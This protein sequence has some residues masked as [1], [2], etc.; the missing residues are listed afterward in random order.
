MTCCKKRSSRAAQRQRAVPSWGGPV[1]PEERLAGVA[2]VYWDPAQ[3]VTFHSGAS[4]A[5]VPN[6]GTLG[7]SRDLVPPPDAFVAPINLG[8]LPTYDAGGW[9]DSQRATGTIPYAY[10]NTAAAFGT[11]PQPS[12]F[13][14]RM[15]AVVKNNGGGNR[16]ILRG[17]DW[18]A[19]IHPT[20][21]PDIVEMPIGTSLGFDETTVPPI[22]E[23]ALYDISFYPPGLGPIPNTNGLADLFIN[24]VR[25]SNSPIEPTIT[26]T[27]S[28]LSI[29]AILDTAGSLAAAVLMPLSAAPADQLLATNV[30][31]DK[32]AAVQP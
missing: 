30:M 13:G 21:V 22:G 3:S 20:D 12:L 16:S 17:V 27:E 8:N 32:L 19:N 15:L 28:F 26:L 2:M 23:W 6:L 11:G 4:V 1:S 29:T 31:L 25:V 5:S 14:A 9:I 24:N 7:P 10:L 18:L